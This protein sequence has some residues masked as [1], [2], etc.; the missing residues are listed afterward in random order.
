M[1][2]RQVL[3]WDRGIRG[4]KVTPVPR[5]CREVAVLLLLISVLCG[6]VPA[7]QG[8]PAASADAI[9]TT[10]NPGDQEPEKTAAPATAQSTDKKDSKDASGKPLK[11]EADQAAAQVAPKEPPTPK[12]GEWLFAPIPISSPA[13]GAGLTWAVGYIFPFTKGDKVS[14]PS[15]IGIG[16]LFTNNGSKAIAIGGKLYLKE[17]K[18]RLTVGIGHAGINADVFGVGKNAGDSG[19]FLP[20]NAK[21]NGFIVEGLFRL[22][23]GIYLGPRVQ[24]RNLALSLNREEAN[25]P[26]LDNPPERVED[27]VAAIRDSLFRQKTVAMGPRF[28]WDTRDNTLYPT[29]GVFLDVGADFFGTAIGSKFTYQYYKVAFNKYSTLAERQVLG[30]RAM[31]C[32]AAGSRIPIYD[33]CLFGTSSDLRGY[34]AGRYQDR[35]MFATQAEYRL[36]LPGQ[37]ILGRFGVVGFGGFG[38]VGRKYSDIGF[39]DLLPAGGG[40]IRFRLTKNNPINFRVDYAFG[41]VGNTLTIGVGEAF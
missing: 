1:D 22:A 14:P 7:R 20:L 29:R 12:R 10:D 25:I 26:D 28:Q 11:S 18:Y 41:R 40:G 21:G 4:N 17:D 32:A 5:V 23:K 15:M 13:I 36:G 6:E 19:I 38:G 27:I 39:S 37:G 9:K 35:R 2:R 34:A 3:E 31:G 33:L 8:A 30:F 24:Y 16:G